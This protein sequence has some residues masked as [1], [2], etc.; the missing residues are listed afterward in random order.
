M[1]DSISHRFVRGVH[2][3]SILVILIM[4]LFVSPQ[5][6]GARR[7]T[8]HPTSDFGIQSSLDAGVRTRRVQPLRT[9]REGS[10]E[11]RPRLARPA[12]GGEVWSAVGNGVSDPEGYALV[13]IENELYVGGYFVYACGD[14]LSCSSG[15]VRVNNIAKWNGSAWAPLGF[16]LN[17]SVNALAVIG[18]DIYVGGAST[19]ICGNANCDSGNTPVNYLAKW[20]TVSNSWSAVSNGTSAAVVALAVNGTDLYVGGAF[21][22]VCGN[23]ACNSGNLQVNSIAKWNGSNWS[24]LNYGLS[25]SAVRPLP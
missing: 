20:S 2:F 25:G 13:R 14:V 22:Q 17:N 11:H 12:A 19:Q 24:A 15:N 1:C 18:N 6:A 7:T 5:P 9:V 3:T 23:A 10:P 16:G 8:A 21:S 4:A